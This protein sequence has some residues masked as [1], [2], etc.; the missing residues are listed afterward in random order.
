MDDDKEINEYLLN[1]YP[2]LQKDEFRKSKSKSK[3]LKRTPSSKNKI[4][5]NI[6]DDEDKQ[7]YE[8]YCKSHKKSGGKMTSIMSVEDSPNYPQLGTGTKYYDKLKKYVVDTGLVFDYKKEISIENMKEILKIDIPKVGDCTFNDRQNNPIRL[9]KN[10]MPVK[11][12]KTIIEGPDYEGVLVKFSGINDSVWKN[13]NTEGVYF[14]TF[15]GFI[16][17]IGMTETSFCKRYGSYCCGDRKA[18]KKGSCSTTNFIICEVCYTALQLGIEVNIYGI[19]I[20]KENRKIEV[21]GKTSNVTISV[22]RGHEEIITKIYKGIN[23]NIPPLCVQ[24]A[25]NTS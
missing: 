3:R 8:K 22:V 7:L 24:H 10:G 6:T 17:K 2:V 4:L 9:K 12:Q 21:Y 15:N 25:S 11:N 20:P 14:I 1:K 18:M 19:N 5:E 16:V 23:G 13:K